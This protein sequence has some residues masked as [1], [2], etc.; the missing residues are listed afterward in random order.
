MPVDIFSIEKFSSALPKHKRTKESLFTHIGVVLGE[1][2]WVCPSPV[3]PKV[4]L[5]I[6]SSIGE[7]GYSASAGMDS[8]KIYI[9]YERHAGKWFRCSEGPDAYTTRVPGWEARLQEKLVQ[10][11][12][13]AKRIVGDVRDGDIITF[14]KRGRPEN[15]GRPMAVCT[16][17]RWLD[18][19]K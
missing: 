17:I 6:R 2:C 10:A 5:L 12:T 4:R 13:K 7:A 9:Q 14:C 18:G 16:P 15:V 8:I 11:I 1:H 19:K 3:N